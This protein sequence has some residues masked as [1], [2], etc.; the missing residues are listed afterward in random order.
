MLDTKQREAYLLQTRE[1]LARAFARLETIVGA[2]PER[3]RLLESSRDKA[4]VRVKEIEE[5]FER[6]RA[7]SEQRHSLSDRAAEER[8]VL[9]A[10]LEKSENHISVQDKRIASLEQELEQKNV[11]L[12]AND[13]AHI[14]TLDREERLAEEILRLKEENAAFERKVELLLEERENLQKHLQKIAEEESSFALSFTQDERLG[15]LK[16]IDTLID[17]VDSMSGHYADVT[18]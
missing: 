1:R 17:R 5:L 8:Q 18:K 13:K 7:I 6:E 12:L 10:K 16:T 4:L 2:M 9:S 15:L 14:E 11:D 3:I